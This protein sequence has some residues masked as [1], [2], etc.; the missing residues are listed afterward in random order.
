M[1]F[2][3]DIV[4][5]LSA[6]QIKKTCCRRSVALGM[7]LCATEDIEGTLVSYFY[8]ES[9]A[10]L[11][12]ELLERVFHSNVNMRQTVRAGRTVYRIT[13]ES[14]AIAEFLSKV[15]DW[16]GEMPYELIG[17]RCASCVSA[18]LRGVFLGCGSVNDPKKGYHLELALPREKRADLVASM[19]DGLTGKTGR[20][21][22]ENRYGIYYKN[23]GSILDL[24][25][26]IGSAKAGEYMTNSFIEKDI[27]NNE[28]RATNCVASNIAMSVKAAQRQISAIESLAASGKLEGLSEE[29]RYTAMLRIENPAASLSELAEAHEPPLSKSGLNRRLNKLMEE[30]EKI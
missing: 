2:T 22:R 12:Y 1:S 25:Y 21:K 3:G 10:S 20:I 5:E 11:A 18:F 26:Y 27:R 23:N 16:K 29:L 8:E 24:L 28:N 19:M 4:R 15:D 7:L 6:L 14:A 13:F 30:S 17:F 9:V